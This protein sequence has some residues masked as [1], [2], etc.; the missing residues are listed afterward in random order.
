MRDTLSRFITN[1]NSLIYTK[2]AINE[3][4]SV[5]LHYPNKSQ[6][7]SSQGILIRE[8]H[9]SQA[10]QVHPISIAQ[11]RCDTYTIITYKR[12]HARSMH[13]ASHA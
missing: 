6:M 11:W 10:H 5:T 4:M 8:R 3:E 7:V 13:T 2:K 12:T 1:A 9:C